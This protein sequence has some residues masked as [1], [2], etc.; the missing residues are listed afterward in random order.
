MSYSPRSLPPPHSFTHAGR[1][2]AYRE[3][4]T[5][6]R[7]VILIHG[8]LMDSRMYARLAPSVAAAGH[9]VITVDMLGHGASDQPH[10]MMR[11]SMPQFGADVVALLDELRIPQAVIAGTSL[12]ANVALEVAVAAPH[13]VRALV[14]EMPVLEHALAVAAA[15]FVP[16]AL[17]L[18]ISRR[19]MRLV[20]AAARAIP[21]S[22][23]LADLL[24]DFVRRDPT[25][26]LAVLDGLTFGRVAPPHQ[27]RTRIEHPTL[28]IGH[29]SDPLHPF[30]DADTTAAEL[31]GARLVEAH[32]I[33]EW[34]LRPERLDRELC[35]FLDEVWLPAGVSA[36]RPA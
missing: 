7:V 3:Y 36:A 15:V 27:D 5:G 16:L 24:I 32:S 26:S 1:R 29:P 4:G 19:T 33:L 14:L 12:G 35:R 30:S 23:Y 25:A 17:A 34:R 2:I 8:L 21:R 11:Y 28:V 31:T 9:R 13:R 20:A 18:R 6:D 22:R 10:D